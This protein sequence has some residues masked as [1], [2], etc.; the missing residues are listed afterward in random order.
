M[1]KKI[2]SGGQTGAD[3][4][5]LDVAID[6]GIPPGGWIPKGRKA[7]DGRL[8][9][10]YMLQETKSINY[11][12]RIELNILD[13]DGTLIISHGKLTGGS[14]RTQN[15]AN[16]HGRPCLHIDLHEMDE[17]KA[18]QV[19][20]SWIDL[21]GIMTLNVAG[22]RASK[23]PE[24][25]VATKRILAHVFQSPPERIVAQ[26]PKTVEEAVERLISEL[27]LKE[28]NNI[29]KMTEE[30]LVSLN[31]LLG[32][33]IGNRYGLLSGNKELMASCSFVMGK[34]DLDKDDASAIIIRK[35][36]EQLKETHALRI[37][38]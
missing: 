11:P 21:R 14:L 10:K 13:S 31:P 7:E 20:S 35:V 8:S 30:D 15:L 33:Y 6:M 12:Q 3:R 2:I 34:K 19:I 1:I 25:H 36:W 5:A 9:D 17:P 16:K 24:I 22:P 26:W 28:K 38:D 29:A 23:D 27:P 37:V 32:K 18:V 4:A